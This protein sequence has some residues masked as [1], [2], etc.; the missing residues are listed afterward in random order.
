MNLAY[1]F[2]AF[3]L[4][5]LLTLAGSTRVATWLIERRNPPAGSFMDIGSARIHY[6]HL[7]ADKPELPPLVFI[8]GASGNLND[9]LAPMRQ[10]LEGKAEMLFFDRPG[11]GWSTRG[12]GNDTPTG[13]AATLSAL[14][15]RLGMEDAI[16]VG[17]SYGGAVAAIFALDHKEKTRGLLFLS[18]A[19]H[20][21]P[22]GETSWYY[23]AT[24]LPV[25]GWIFSETV[26]TLVG[27]GRIGDAT[28]CVFAP[29]PVPEGYV[30]RASIPLVLRP[31]AFRAN[32]VDVAGL[33][34]FVRVNAPRYSR[35]TAPSIVVTGNR[36]TIVYEE[37]HSGGLARDI[38]GAEIVWVDNLG[39]KPDWIAP[40]LVVS[41]IEKLSGKPVDLAA[42]KARV[43]QRIAADNFATDL[44]AEPQMPAGELSPQ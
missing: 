10:A 5:L 37:L 14:M 18:P 26:T 29:N 41:A 35:I 19:T 42:V 8:H 17:H 44:C 33:Y 34:D 25:G 1:A 21:W 23:S 2:L 32:A 36:D 3:L 20:P 16:V 38:P 12:S 6:V 13:Q 24:A 7:K 4:A 31:S 22:G 39:H 11:H 27:W 40:E 30:D 28:A 9:Q 43:E 15:D